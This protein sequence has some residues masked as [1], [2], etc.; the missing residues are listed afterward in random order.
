M[1][2]K[3][4]GYTLIEFLIAMA[5]G[6]I[7]ITVIYQ[8][9]QARQN[10]NVKQQLVVEMQENIRAAV[11]LI[12]REIRM[13][14]YDPA[15]NDGEDS[16]GDS[17]I[18]NVE[19]SAGTGI[20]K[21]GRSMISFTFDYDA[22]MTAGTDERITY[23][24]ANLYDPDGNGIADSG[25]APLGRATG[26]GQ[27]IPIAE[28]IQAIGF[29]YAFDHNHDG[30]LDTDDGAA[31]GRIVWAFDADLSDGNEALTTNLDNHLPLASAVPLS[32]IRAIRVWILAR[33]R[34]PIRGYFE[35]RTYAVGDRNI[36]CSD[37]YPRRLLTATVYCRNLG[38]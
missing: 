38:L 24:F 4:G 22:D 18:D 35:N 23:G 1:R 32:D 16:D 21:A 20:K 30:I 7:L 36:S 12:K 11:S 14:G 9:Y 10:S 13:T 37:R 27:L 26:S 5:I 2:N 17:T 6:A 8:I 19:E 25:A 28:N 34:A 15:A 3:S 31:D 29:A 33:T